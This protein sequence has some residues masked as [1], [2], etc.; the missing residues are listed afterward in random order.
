MRLKVLR[1]D[2]QIL[3][4]AAREIHE[5]LLILRERRGEFQR[6]GERV[7]R[8]KRR[9]DPFNVAELLE[10]VHRFVIRDAHVLGAANI[11]EIAV[12]GTDP[13]VIKPRGD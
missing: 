10:S 13:R 4:T 3:V 8:L 7:A 6:V 5:N 11:R 1:H 12:L 9:D 2:S